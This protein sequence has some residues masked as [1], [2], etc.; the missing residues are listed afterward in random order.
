MRPIFGF[1]GGPHMARAKTVGFALPEEMLADLDIVV[2]EFAGGNRSE[3]L[4]IAVRHYR[5]Q[6]MANRMAA[7]RAEAKAQRG[8]RTYTADEVRVMVAELKGK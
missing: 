2:T 8:G 4:R 5:A 1:F 7:L 3:F 6:M